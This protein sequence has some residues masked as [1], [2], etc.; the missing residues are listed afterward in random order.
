MGSRRP[1]TPE[2]GDDGRRIAEWMLGNEGWGWPQLEWDP[3]LGL[4][5]PSL[6]RED[7]SFCGAELWKR[8]DV[9]GMPAGAGTAHLGVGVCWRHDRPTER[10]T[11][12]WIV[13][14]AMARI[15]DITPWEALLLAVKR[16]AAWAA[17]YEGKVAEVTD[18]EE[19]RPGGEAHDWV[20]ALERVNDKLARYSK[21]A[22][23]AGVAAML[24]QRA[25][26]EGETIARVL[27]AA[28]SEAGLGEEA[29][30]RLRAALRNAL[31]AVEAVPL[32]GP[33]S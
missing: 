19:L 14:H 22:V 4:A 7:V 23:D 20:A 21:M 18:D 10:A 15:E 25:R 16:A 17:F 28:I 12:A 5:V 8:E 24:V 32:A 27:N 3:E 1:V 26:T 2:E 29:E 33:E 9:C 31:L 13:A 30:T 11:G 6:R